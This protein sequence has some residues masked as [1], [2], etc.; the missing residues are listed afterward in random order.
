MHDRPAHEMTMEQALS[1]HHWRF[2][3]I[4][5]HVRPLLE[6]SVGP[7]SGN[8]ALTLTAAHAGR[9]SGRAAS[10]QIPLIIFHSAAFQKLHI[11]LLKRALPVMLFLLGNVFPHHVPLRGT[12]GESS[13]SLL[14]G[15]PR[16]TGFLMHPARGNGFHIAHDIREARRRPEADEEMDVV[17]NATDGFWHA[18]HIP[19]HATEIGVQSPAPS[20]SDV[21]DAVLRAEDEVIV[22]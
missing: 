17:S 1:S 14:L 12:H 15:K 9:G 10:P 18:L 21:R 2:M 8:S 19:H 11:L 6:L 16:I 3:V 13:V 5:G 7:L 4:G 20:F 22:K